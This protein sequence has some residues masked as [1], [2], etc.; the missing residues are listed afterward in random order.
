[1]EIKWNGDEER[2]PKHSFLKSYTLRLGRSFSESSRLSHSFYILSI[3]VVYS[4]SKIIGA[5]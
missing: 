4:K 5:I 2:G 1:M 3:P